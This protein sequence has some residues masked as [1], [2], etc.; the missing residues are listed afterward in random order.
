MHT[1]S[2]GIWRGNKGTH[3]PSKEQAGSHTN[4]DGKE[5]V[6]HHIPGQENKY[7]GNRKTKVTDV[8]EQV[9]GPG[10]GTSAEYEKTDGHCVPPAGNPTKGNDLEEDPAS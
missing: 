6:K 2:N 4:K 3:Q 9:S 10:Q 8:I 7:L 5:Y 1:S